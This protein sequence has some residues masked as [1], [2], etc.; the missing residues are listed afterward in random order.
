MLLFS[1]FLYFELIPLITFRILHS[2]AIILS[3][4]P[5]PYNVLA[6]EDAS[7]GEDADGDYVAEM[8][9]HCKESGVE[10]QSIEKHDV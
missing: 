10:T 4:N 7:D 2:Y 8:Q 5:D 3:R 1:S 9:D 6:S